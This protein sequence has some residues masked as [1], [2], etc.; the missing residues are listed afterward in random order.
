MFRPANNS[1]GKFP[2]KN[3]LPEEFS[4]D[5]HLSEKDCY[6]DYKNDLTVGSCNKNHTNDSINSL[7][8]ESC[9]KFM[10]HSF[11]ERV[12]EG[13]EKRYKFKRTVC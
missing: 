5:Y 8:K 9:Y 10:V 3:K 11:L 13:T 2:N 12:V 4:N 7:G 6:K 1:S